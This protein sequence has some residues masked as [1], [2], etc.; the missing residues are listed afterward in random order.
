MKLGVLGLSLI[1]VFSIANQ[2]NPNVD[3]ESKAANK[4]T[5]KEVIKKEGRDEAESKQSESRKQQKQEE[6]EIVI[7]LVDYSAY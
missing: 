6:E 3:K 7:D 2:N 1:L 4:E 5:Q